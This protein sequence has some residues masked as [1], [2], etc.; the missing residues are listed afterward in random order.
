[1]RRAKVLRVTPLGAA[2]VDKT[3]PAVESFERQLVIYRLKNRKD[4]FLKHLV[5]LSKAEGGQA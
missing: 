5:R 1:M 3:V 4:S 2:L